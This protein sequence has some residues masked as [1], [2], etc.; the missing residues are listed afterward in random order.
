MTRY[1]DKYPIWI[2]AFSN[3]EITKPESITL[4]ISDLELRAYNDP[5]NPGYTYL[6][7]LTKDALDEDGFYWDK[8]LV[9]PPIKDDDTTI[10]SLHDHNSVPEIILGAADF[11]R[12]FRFALMHQRDPRYKKGLV[13]ITLKVQ[14]TP[15]L[16][17]ILLDENMYEVNK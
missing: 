9:E 17:Y 15:F 14:R 12:D 8:E 1:Q 5:S 11:K 3:S 2:R 10:Q 16:G 4:K 6:T 7:L 13:T